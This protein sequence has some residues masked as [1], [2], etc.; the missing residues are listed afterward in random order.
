MVTESTGHTNDKP[1]RSLLVLAISTRLLTLAFLST[2]SHLSPL[3]FDTSHRLLSPA[4]TSQNPFEKPPISQIS[5]TAVG[6]RWDSI[7]FASIAVD[8]YQYEQQMAFM[9]GWP[10]VMHMSGEVVYHLRSRIGMAVPANVSSSRASY[11][12]VVYGGMAVNFVAG[13]WATLTLYKYVPFH[14]S[15]FLPPP[16]P[17][18]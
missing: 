10:L 1:P 7:H 5:H 15:L 11:S 13:I 14:H 9:P 6:L 16:G 12:D 17:T 3:S 2:L 4:G 8:G 18:A